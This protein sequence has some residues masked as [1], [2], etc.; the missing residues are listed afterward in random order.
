MPKNNLKR[1]GCKH[2]FSSIFPPPPPPKKK[3]L[4][5]VRH[6]KAGGLKCCYDKKI[7]SFSSSYLENVFAYHL[8]SKIFSFDF[9]SKAV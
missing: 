4:L 6:L 5:I 8:T 7:T 2:N 1:S 3:H 9:Y